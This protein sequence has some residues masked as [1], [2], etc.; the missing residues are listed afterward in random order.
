MITP[1][2]IHDAIACIEYH[3]FDGTTMLACCITLKNGYPVIGYAFAAD[4]ANFDLL[5][6]QQYA[7]DDAESK[8]A[9]L[10]AYSLK[11]KS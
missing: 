8:I 5:K 3:L 4:P 9:E 6:F 7:Q 2:Q 11:G 10:L 1:Q